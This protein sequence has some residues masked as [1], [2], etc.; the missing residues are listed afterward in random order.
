[1][2]LVGGIA[3]AAVTFLVIV[4][5]LDTEGW[6][7]MLL[8]LFGTPLFGLLLWQVFVAAERK[9]WIHRAPTPGTFTPTR[10]ERRLP[11]SGDG[12]A[13]RIK[14]TDHLHSCRV[15]DNGGVQRSVRLGLQPGGHPG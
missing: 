8:G 13:S 7:W 14:P 11:P 6:R 15:G 3:F 4:L 12:L 10:S 9:G 2:G 1:M 5:C